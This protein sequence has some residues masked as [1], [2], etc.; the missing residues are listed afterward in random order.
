MPNLSAL[1]RRCQGTGAYVRTD[2][3]PEV[4]RGYPGTAA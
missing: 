2:M 3:A 4:T 1:R